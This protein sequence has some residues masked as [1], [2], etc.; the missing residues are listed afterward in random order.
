MSVNNFVVRSPC[1]P[2]Y[3]LNVELEWEGPAY[4]QSQVHSGYWCNAP[5]CFNEWDAEGHPI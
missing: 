4:V 5:G 2:E 1:H 3:G